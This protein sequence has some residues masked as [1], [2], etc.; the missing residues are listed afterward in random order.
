MAEFYDNREWGHGQRPLFGK[1][2]NNKQHGDL[3]ARYS[4]QLPSKWANSGSYHEVTAYNSD[5]DNIGHMQWH[6]KTGEIIDVR[7]NEEHQRKGVATAL[8]SMAH[9]VAGEFNVAKPVHSDDRSD[10]GD[11]WAK[12]IGGPLPKRKTVQDYE[13]MWG[14]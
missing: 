1:V 13:E 11:E 4:L 14:R 2:L 8:H 9:K 10:Q 6:V 3:Y 12:S 5:H 7:V